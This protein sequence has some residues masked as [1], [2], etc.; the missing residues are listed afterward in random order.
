M[1]KAFICKRT[2]D[3][4]TFDDVHTDCP[5][6]AVD[7]YGDASAFTYWTSG[8]SATLPVDPSASHYEFFYYAGQDPA[9]FTNEDYYIGPN[10]ATKVNNYPIINDPGQIG[11][12]GRSG[13]LPYISGEIM[14]L[15]F[16]NFGSAHVLFPAERILMGAL[17]DP[18]PIAVAST[19][20]VSKVSDI[21][22]GNPTVTQIPTID[23]DPSGVY[24]GAT[25]EFTTPEGATL[26]V[27][28]INTST[29]PL[30][31][32]DIGHYLQKNGV[33]VARWRHADSL[34]GPGVGCYG[35]WP[36]VPGD[37]WNFRGYRATSVT[38]DSTHCSMEFY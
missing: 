38:A 9:I 18:S 12:G 15:R 37:T 27:P 11:R 8:V 36:T 35:L 5:W 25:G 22:F 3:W 16:R 28:S 7:N 10:G 14:N 30:S 17:I 2:T 21:T 19:G 31:T 32:S 4:Q 26:C 6:E 20:G 34:R 13:L 29:D 23:F 1:V 24:N 33:E